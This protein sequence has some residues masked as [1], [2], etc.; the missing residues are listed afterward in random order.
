MGFFQRVFRAP[1]I[2]TFHSTP[3][4]PDDLSGNVLIPGSKG[5]VQDHRGGMVTTATQLAVDVPGPRPAANL[6]TG[7]TISAGRVHVTYDTLQPHVPVREPVGMPGNQEFYTNQRTSPTTIRQS[8]L[9]VPLAPLQKVKA[10]TQ[11]RSK[12]KGSNS[13]ETYA[14]STVW[15]GGDPAILRKQQAH[16]PSQQHFNEH[17]QVEGNVVWVPSS[18]V[19]VPPLYYQRGWYQAFIPEP[20]M[21]LSEVGDAPP[22]HLSR[23]LSVSTVIAQAVPLSPGKP[24]KAPTRQRTKG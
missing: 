3:V 16:T 5:T 6:H 20:G 23:P 14:G 1:P 21:R 18:G 17:K 11:I 9:D 19:F 13:A 8:L 15:D 12:T 10:P 7:E 24:G 4:G 2:Q 22:V